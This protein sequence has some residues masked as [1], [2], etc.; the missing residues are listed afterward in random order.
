MPQDPKVKG[1]IL[2][3]TSS[4]ESNARQTANP[5]DVTLSPVVERA[6]GDLTC[7]QS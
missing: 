1:G 7:L 2:Q 5:P 4:N 6:S 3:R